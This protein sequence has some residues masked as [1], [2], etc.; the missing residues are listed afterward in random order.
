MARITARLF[1]DTPSL[2]AEFDAQTLAD[3]QAVVLLSLG[4]E[5][6]ALA[7][8]AER[9][10]RQAAVCIADCYGIVGFSVEQGRNLEL[11]EPGRGREY[12]GP[13]GDGGRGVVAVLFSSGF[14]GSVED[15]PEDATSHLVVSSSGGVTSYLSRRNLG[16]YYGGVAK[17]VF[18]VAPGS[19]RLERVAQFFVSSEAGSAALVGLTSFT[20]DVSGN[21]TRLLAGMP[22]GYQADAVALMPCFMRGKNTYG[23]NDVEPAAISETLPGVPLFG[24]FCHGELG[25]SGCLGFGAGRDTQRSHRLHSMTSIVAVHASRQSV[26][27]D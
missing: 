4:L 8:F 1:S 9:A 27:P 16:P 18:R 6:S 3:A 21:M 11:M 5:P 26:G 7:A 2:E 23:N 19:S 25:P 13:G 24:M 22:A 17:Q 14:V 10:A 12:G 20:D 15:P